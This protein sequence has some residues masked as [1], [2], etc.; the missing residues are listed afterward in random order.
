MRNHKTLDY[1]RCKTLCI[2]FVA[3]FEWVAKIG[4]LIGNDLET[5]EVLY[6]AL[7]NPKNADFK[8]KGSELVWIIIIL[9]L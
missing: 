1:T 3:E 7:L 5:S 9:V 2:V 6:S 8:C 4:F